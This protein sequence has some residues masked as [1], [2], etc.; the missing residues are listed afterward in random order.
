MVLTTGLS[1]FI[2]LFTAQVTLS[3]FTVGDFAGSGDLKSFGDSFV[4][5]SHDE[6]FGKRKIN[7][8]LTPHDQAK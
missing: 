7:S 5:L 3:G 2:G 1:L 6:N 4:R 8:D